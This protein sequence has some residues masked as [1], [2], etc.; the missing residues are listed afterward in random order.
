MA[1]NITSLF[2]KVATVQAVIKATNTV[3]KY[4]SLVVPKSIA[5]VQAQVPSRAMQSS[6]SNNTMAAAIKTPTV[7]NVKSVKKAIDAIS[8]ATHV[9]QKKPRQVQISKD[10]SLAP[11]KGG[12]F[13]PYEELLGV[14][15]L[16]PEIVLCMDYVP[17]FDD[18]IKT[19]FK[20]V[21]DA[22]NSL[23]INTNMLNDAGLFVNVQSKLL[24]LRFEAIARLLSDL[25]EENKDF[26]DLL[27]SKKDEINTNLN[28][29]QR[30]VETLS[31]LVDNFYEF[32]EH[33][34][35]VGVNHRSL[36]IDELTNRYFSNEF[37]RTWHVLGGREVSSTFTLEKLQKMNTYLGRNGAALLLNGVD[38][39]FH[40]ALLK[41][42]Y[43]T[44]NIKNFSNTKVFL[45]SVYE[46]KLLL[47]GVSDHMLGLNEN[48][49]ANDTDPIQLNVHGISSDNAS[50]EQL[51]SF[52]YGLFQ[53]TT[54]LR[55]ELLGLVKLQLPQAVQTVKDT[56]FEIEKSLTPFGITTKIAYMT[57]FV[58]TEYAYSHGILNN[59]FQQA[60]KGYH[61]F[62]MNYVASN[63]KLLDVVFGYVGKTIFDD[64][65]TPDAP[66][67]YSSVVHT[68][69]KINNSDIIV[70]NMEEDYID[71]E[72]NTYTPGEVY[73]TGELV[74][75]VDRTIPEATKFN[76]EVLEDLKKQANGLSTSISSFMQ[77]MRILTPLLLGA[78]IDPNNVTD[79]ATLM[80]SPQAIFQHLYYKYLLNSGN[81]HPYEEVFK[82][83]T[84]AFLNKVG[85]NRTLKSYFFIYMY[86]WVKKGDFFSI[87]AEV[88]NALIDSMLAI[89]LANNKQTTWKPQSDLS[90]GNWVGSDYEARPNVTINA[91][92]VLRRLSAPESSY[93][94][95]SLRDTFKEY[96]NVF[97]KNAT[98]L[99]VTEYTAFSY[100][101]LPVM[102]MFIFELMLQTHNLFVNDSYM[103]K[104]SKGMH[105][106]LSYKHW[107]VDVNNKLAIDDVHHRLNYEVA[108]RI[109]ATAPILEHADRLKTAVD[110][111]QKVVS[112]NA[113]NELMSKLKTIMNDKGI[114]MLL[115]VQQVMMMFTT[116]SNMRKQMALNTTEDFVVYDKT[117]TSELFNA[118]LLYY[119]S[120]AHSSTSTN[121]KVFS[122]GIPQGF[123]KRLR[124]IIKKSKK[125]ITSFAE[126][127][128]DVIRIS[129]HKID[130]D[131]ND[132]IFN[133]IEMLFELSR[134]ILDDD[135]N[136][137]KLLGSKLTLDNIVN[138]FVT[139]DY[140]NVDTINGQSSVFNDINSNPQY[141]FLSIDQKKELINNHVKSYYLENY[142][143]LLTG[144]PVLERELL[145]DT[146]VAV[147]KNIDA[148]VANVMI[149]ALAS[150]VMKRN[151]KDAATS[152]G[153]VGIVERE[154]VDTAQIESDT[155]ELITRKQYDALSQFIDTIDDLSK[156]KTSL[157]DFNTLT[158]KLL[159]PKMFDR[160]FFVLLSSDD[161]TID[162]QTTVSTPA[163]KAAFENLQRSDRIE[164][165]V[166]GQY[167]M[168]ARKKD[169]NAFLFEK[170][171]VTIDTVFEGT[172]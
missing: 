161:F 101:H 147:T 34:M 73:Y 60:M 52:D 71:F 27:N 49:Y 25:K 123:S 78:N 139:T 110:N 42:G 128:S 63:R 115:D 76:I 122:V 167:K 67:P 85:E 12:T 5:P 10:G 149:D 140:N 90:G 95:R 169:E 132:I 38:T 121:Y 124:N 9:Y 62:T 22:V 104:N 170:Y 134:F 157:S 80:G 48:K 141:D 86:L 138:N 91:E 113:T 23:F 30:Y 156:M 53:V 158:D 56:F 127:Q 88:R 84:T 33:S 154:T 11:Q 4:V 16:Q 37:K 69:K 102:Y 116:L 46:A 166:N 164:T 160:I 163:G 36:T 40:N 144:V 51:R 2:K 47:G 151:I 21:D 98:W 75:F 14:S 92:I 64:T 58:F 1:I 72:N 137:E 93:V 55:S 3:Q 172:A 45:Q 54:I 162:Y 82:D 44:N 165:T 70:M 150:K 57:M 20:D 125:G 8:K 79:D 109:M 19:S 13:K 103:N 111:I 68:K 119:M 61:G 83:E 142:V 89:V 159:M 59:D 105:D 35:Y 96:I 17:L 28:L 66:T 130:V 107:G 41:F 168:K 29:M 148:N 65:S 112:D 133:H 32:Y 152:L 39:N 155:R 114:T 15:S 97:E 135:A 43:S 153:N 99:G 26:I 7:F 50:G 77:N 18:V 143:R 118:S 117:L 129:V 74:K 146:S 106:G 6:K 136:Y 126:K 24:K 145:V 131:N 31:K 120:Q 81:M 100:M 94:F 108:M 87:N 171:F